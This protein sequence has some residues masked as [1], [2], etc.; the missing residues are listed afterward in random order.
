MDAFIKMKQRKEPLLNLENS[1][2]DHS[3]DNSHQRPLETEATA[4][5]STLEDPSD[6]PCVQEYFDDC[7]W[8]G[9]GLFG[10][11]YLLFSVGTLQPLWAILFPNCFATEDTCRSWVL[12]SVS[13]AVVLGVIC[14]MIGVGASAQTLGRR[15]GSILT[16]AFMTVGAFGL[17]LTAFVAFQDDD[18][19]L[20]VALAACLFVFGIGVG[21]E[22]PLS[23]SSASEKAMA[24]AVKKT[25]SPKKE[26]LQVIQEDE[27]MDTNSGGQKHRGRRIQLV[28]SMQ[29]MGIF[30]NSLVMTILLVLYG[31]TDPD[32]YNIRALF[33][34]WQWTY[35]IGFLVL[36]Y[37]LFSRYLYLQESAVWQKDKEKRDQQQRLVMSTNDNAHDASSVAAPGAVASPSNSTA[38]RPTQLAS[39]PS[40]V[41]SLSAPSLAAIDFDEHQVG[42]PFLSLKEEVNGED[43][44]EDAQLPVW[45]LL[46]KHFGVRLVGVSSCWFLWDI[47]FYGNK[48]FQSSFLLAISGQG[49]DSEEPVSLVAFS[50]AASLNAGVALLGY[51]GAAFLVD[52]PWIGRR[53]LQQ[54]GFFLTG[55]LFVSCGF[56]Y[57]SLSSTTLCAFY[58]GSSFFGQLGPNAT[59]F[60]LPAEVFPTQVRTSCHGVAASAGKAGALVAAV[61]FPLLNSDLDMFL[62]SGYASLMASAVTL[63]TIPETTGLDLNEL[64]RKWWLMLQGRRTEYQGPANHPRFLSQWERH[65]W[66][67]QHHQQSTSDLHYNHAMDDF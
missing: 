21:G 65:R 54:W 17:T 60:C 40:D 32:D 24:E 33:R 36:L 22:Y 23:A 7:L 26:A 58:L 27:P 44:A 15:T 48:L 30:C 57:N 16:A 43:V 39:P 34:V 52:R 20:V 41:S 50:M 11:S 37:V 35:V 56:F 63:W 6:K 14:G 19:R 2:K 1:L 4:N 61:F 10:E 64:D 55:A 49:T 38:D 28:F 59:T 25:Q 3:L 45:T 29:G 5:L 46:L 66:S 9:L 18:E 12:N 67:V 53:Q 13:Y 8:P 47:A 62:L 42:G 31:Q 51:F